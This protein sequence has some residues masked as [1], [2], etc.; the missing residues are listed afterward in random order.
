[1]VESESV[2]IRK[3]AALGWIVIDRPNKLNALDAQTI[4]NLYA[5]FMSLRDN[6]EIKCVILTGSGDKA[7]IAGA[8]IGELAELDYAS[9]KDYVLEG[10]ELTKLIE[11]YRKPVIAAINGYALGGGTELALACHIR[12]A[13]E[14][15]K[16]GQPEVKLGLIPGFGGTQRL[17]RLVGKGKA[18]ELILSG[19]MIDAQEALAIGLINRVVPLSDLVSSCETLAGEMIA[20]SPLA[21][22]YSIRAINEGLD[23]SL[24]EGLL[25]EAELFGTACSSEDSDEGT[26]AFLEKRKA[27]FQG[28]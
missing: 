7:F 2:K 12:I 8:D 6:P 9:G 25:L 23:K 18:M 22:E 11:N 14:N 4:K 17:A 5:A 16:M 13:A 20:N 21:M 28:K 27:H 26:K 3:E 19:K 10:Q 15:A 1:M 24:P